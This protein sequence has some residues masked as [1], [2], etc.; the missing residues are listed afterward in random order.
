M[1]L[2]LVSVDP[3]ASAKAEVIEM[4]KVILEQAEAGS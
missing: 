3:K 1:A 4:A 2:T